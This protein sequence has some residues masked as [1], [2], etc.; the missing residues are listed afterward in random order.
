MKFLNKV[1]ANEQV[2]FSQYTPDSAVCL[3]EAE[4]L[5]ELLS[6]RVGN[7][8]ATIWVEKPELAP[9]LEKANEKMKVIK[10]LYKLIKEINGKMK[11]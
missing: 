11:I 2:T 8:L 1:E 5:L 9:L 4:A 10:E 7:G 6:D 3:D